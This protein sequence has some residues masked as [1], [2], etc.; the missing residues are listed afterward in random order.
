MGNWLTKT[1]DSVTSIDGLGGDLLIGGA[2][3]AAGLLGGPIVG[4]AVAAGVSGLVSGARG[5]AGSEILT[6][7]AL[8][9]L[10][11]FGGGALIGG[12][13]RL[14]G[15]GM[16]ASS[17][18]ALVEAG[19]G[20]G[21]GNGI[22]KLTMAGYGVR[23]A[24]GGSY[25]R[26]ITSAVATGVG[27]AVGSNGREWYADMAPDD[28]SGVLGQVPTKDYTAELISSGRLTVPSGYI[29]HVFGPDRTS[30]EWPT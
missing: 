21:V 14:G 8:G 18:N 30:A 10:A 5:N 29:A 3:L 20:F 26:Y 25:G 13:T 28:G 6:D 4:A 16:F 7:M 9:S 17:G 12:A 11:G 1:W 2:G 24:M 15:R 23:N 19:R 27:A 22:G